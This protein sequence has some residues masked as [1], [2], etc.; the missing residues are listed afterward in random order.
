MAGRLATTQAKRPGHEFPAPVP[1]WPK[2]RACKACFRWFESDRVLDMNATETAL[3]FACL[4]L[5]AGLAIVATMLADRAIVD[6]TKASH[7]L[8]IAAASIFVG[9]ICFK[10]LVESFSP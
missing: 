1:E 9:G 6:D 8:A 4:A 3:W 7:W 10:G 2:G 5:S